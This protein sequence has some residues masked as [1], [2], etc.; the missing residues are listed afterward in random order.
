M[1]YKGY[2]WTLFAPLIRKSIEKR[3]GKNM[4]DLAVRNGKREYRRILENADE[5]GPGNPMASNA[6]FA[7]VFVGAW[8]GTGRQIPP[9]GMAEVMKDVLTK[10]KP[11]FGM[12]NM[13]K[14]PRKWHDDM[15]KYEAWAKKNK[16]KYPAAWSVHFDED[17]HRDGSFYY[18]TS[19]P[20][21]A[22]M[23]KMGYPEIMPGLCATDEVMFHYQHAVLHRDHTL[24]K[25]EDVCDYWVVGDKVRDPE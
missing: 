15:K 10:L 9:E 17:L 24:A 2:Y 5:I 20:I 14:T 23:K 21:C 19:C 25:G 1:K 18:F 8:L 4:A 22:C 12:T 3:Y 16:E 11:F 13:N 7:Y 6:Y